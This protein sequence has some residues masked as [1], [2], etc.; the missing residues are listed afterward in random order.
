MRFSLN[1]TNSTNRS[2]G[3]AFKRLKEPIH[4][5]SKTNMQVDIYVFYILIA[6][7]F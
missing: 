4:S 5:S 3:E 2:K 6:Y 7:N 1:Q